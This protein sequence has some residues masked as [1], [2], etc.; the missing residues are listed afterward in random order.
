MAEEGALL[1]QRVLHG[2]IRPDP[3]PTASDGRLDRPGSCRTMGPSNHPTPR[4]EGPPLTEDE[5]HPIVSGLVALVGVGVVVGLLISGGALAASSMLG[6]SGGDDGGTASSQQSMYLPK[7]SA[8][9]PETGPQVTL[10]PGEETPSPTEAGAPVTPEFAISL[11]AAETEVGPMEEIYLTGV[12]PGG[13]GAVVQVQRFESGNVG[14]LRVRRR[15]GQQRDVLDLRPDRADRRQQVPGPR[16]RRARRSPTR[17]GSTA[18]LS[19]LSAARSRRCRGSGRVRPAS[20]RSRAL[21][22]AT[23]S[24][25]ELEVEDG[26]VLLH[27]LAVHR[28]REH[29]VAALDVPAQGHLRRRASV[30]GGD[31]ADHRRRRAPRPA[32]S[33][34]TPRRGRRAGGWPRGRRRW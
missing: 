14:G 26:E 4:P 9:D 25:V 12:Y 18:A 5:G 23:S 33:A 15:R 29:D 2:D 27:P 20:P 19:S 10:Q 1:G 31:L 13:E 16:H 11:S 32:R 28:L 7:P 3:R 24:A 34:T 30:R 8:T 6:L 17:C 21:I 22:A